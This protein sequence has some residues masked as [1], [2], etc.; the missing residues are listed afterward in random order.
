MWSKGAQKGSIML[1]LINTLEKKSVLVKQQIN[2]MK[3]MP[4]F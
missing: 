1:L 3:T 2:N 4:D